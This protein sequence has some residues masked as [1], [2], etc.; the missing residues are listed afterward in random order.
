LCRHLAEAD[1]AQSEVAHKTMLAAAAKTAP[2]D[3]AGK[4]WALFA[5][6]DY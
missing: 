6:R 1:P 2:N 3:P 4:L 5:S